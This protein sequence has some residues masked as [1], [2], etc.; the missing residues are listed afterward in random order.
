MFFVSILSLASCS[1][2][3]EA[4]SDFRDASDV[5]VRKIKDSVRV[6][7]GNIK[8]IDLQSFDSLF[9]DRTRVVRE[10]DSAEMAE[11]GINL[12]GQ[13]KAYVVFE[14]EVRERVSQLKTH[15]ADTLRVESSSSH[16]SL[17]RDS[18]SFVSKVEKEKVCSNT[19]SRTPFVVMFV[20]SLLLVVAVYL[21]WNSG[22][23]S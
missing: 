14:K 7:T 6:A 19:P 20:I 23:P 12:Q 2:K 13:K 3:R 21:L 10:A 5:T 1:I 9:I 18:T 11:F 22:K 17:E 16:R 8:L 15:S 4:T